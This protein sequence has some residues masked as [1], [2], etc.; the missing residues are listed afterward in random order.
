MV[1]ISFVTLGVVS[2]PTGDHI[3]NLSVISVTDEPKMTLVTLIP[4]PCSRVGAEHVGQDVTSCS[5]AIGSGSSPLGS[6]LRMMVRMWASRP[7]SISIPM[8]RSPVAARRSRPEK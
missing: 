3:E 2:T 1:E 7:K 6:Y 5:S 4:E 8:A